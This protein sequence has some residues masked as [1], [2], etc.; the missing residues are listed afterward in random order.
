MMCVNNEEGDVNENYD[1][2]ILPTTN[3]VDFKNIKFLPPVFAVMMTIESGE[4]LAIYE[5][6]YC[7]HNDFPD[8]NF[9]SMSFAGK[10]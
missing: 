6:V 2:N 7:C 9:L 3:K 1:F 4:N 10:T 5:E 8:H